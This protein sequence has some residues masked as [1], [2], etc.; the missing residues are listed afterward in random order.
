MVIVTFLTTIWVL[1]A[2]LTKSHDPPSSV[3][4]RACRRSSEAPPGICNLEY[5]WLPNL[6]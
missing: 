2:L 1:I 5:T 3:C 6:I 4:K